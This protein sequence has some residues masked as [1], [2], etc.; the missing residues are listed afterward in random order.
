MTVVHASLGDFIPIHWLLWRNYYGICYYSSSLQ[1][2]RYLSAS[3]IIRWFCTDTLTLVKELLCN[4]L[5][6]YI[7]TIHVSAGEAIQWITS[8]AASGC[9]RTS[10]Q[11]G[12]TEAEWRPGHQYGLCGTQVTYP[13][14]RWTH[15]PGSHCAANRGKCGCDSLSVFLVQ[16]QLRTEVLRT[17]S[18]TPLRF[19]LIA[20]RSWHWDACSNHLAINDFSLPICLYCPANAV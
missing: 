18:S 9:K 6:C 3:F 2:V 11:A 12:C 20:S 19:E 4:L 5:T 16:V 15:L 7:S 8:R 13:R 1:L 17:P 14:P 10:R